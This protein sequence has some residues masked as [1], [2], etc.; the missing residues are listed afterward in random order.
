MLCLHF[1]HQGSVGADTVILSISTDHAA[2]QS[3]IHCFVGRYHLD[4]GTAE[5][6]F[7]NAVAV[8]QKF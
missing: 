6:C 7:C 2:I 3:D 4:L 8:M 5:I 1:C